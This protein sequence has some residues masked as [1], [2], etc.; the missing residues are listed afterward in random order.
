LKQKKQVFEDSLNATRAAVEEGIIPGGGIILLRAAE[1]LASL[2]LQGDEATGA[3]LLAKA[4]QAPFKQIVENAGF[5]PLLVLEEVMEKG[6]N[7]GFNAYSDEVDDLLQAGVID[8]AKVVK[9][10]LIFACSSAGIFF[11]S[12]CLIG[13]A[14]E[15]ETHAS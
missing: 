6:A 5:D 12:E 14:P 9:N 11:L 8:P 2:K 7:F 3:Q 13:N 1:L 4:C 15:E 10:A